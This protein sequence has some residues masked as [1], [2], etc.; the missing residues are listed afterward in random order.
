[1]PKSGEAL[2]KVSI[3]GICNTDLELVKGYMDFE[4][5]LGHEFVG[6]IFFLGY[7]LIGLA[8]SAQTQKRFIRLALLKSLSF[9]K[10]L[11]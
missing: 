9:R 3:A 4:G 1:M 10:N 5:V 8:N 2:V 6:P 11:F 7:E